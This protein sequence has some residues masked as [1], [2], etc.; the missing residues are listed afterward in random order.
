[1]LPVDLV[2]KLNQCATTDFVGPRDHWFNCL[3][4]FTTAVFVGLVLEF[5]ELRYELRLLARE[6]IPYFRYRIITPR[7]RRVHAAKLVAFIGWFLIVIGVGGERYAEVRVKDLD[8]SIQGCS[9]AKVIAATLEAG[10]AAKSAKTAHDEAD[11]VKQKADA[12]DIRLESASRKLG[13]IEQDILAQG[14][15]WRLLKKGEDIFIKALK[16]FAGQQVTVVNCGNGDV[17]R[18]GLEQAFLNIFPKAGWNS[19]GY[20]GWAGCP[21]MLTGGNEIFFVAA[22]DDSSEWASVPAQQWLKP[23]CG[24]FNGSHDAVNTL[25][26][27]LY[28]L[29]IFTMAFR[30]KPLPPEVGIQ[31]ARVFF[32]FGATGGPAELAYKDPGRIFLLIGPNAP[33]FTDKRIH[34]SAK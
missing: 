9:D 6:W 25:C 5:P 33:M 7:Q 18:E 13:D 8:A 19:P 24:R 16:P 10:D 34:K 4:G 27:V 2:A 1:M 11:A 26:D 15:R 30:E 28:K 32:G 20:I 14:P 3:A 21:N 22:T 23:Q 31:N 29:R 12:L 17:E